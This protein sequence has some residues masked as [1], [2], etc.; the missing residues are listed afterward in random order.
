VE[1]RFSSGGVLGANYTW[2]KFLS[3]TDTLNG[4]ADP[5]GTN[6]PSGGSGSIQ[7]YNNPKAERSIISFDIPQRLVVDYVLNLPFGKGQKFGAKANGVVNAAISGW[8]VNG[9]TT[10]E[11]GTPAYMS[12][13]GGNSLTNLF[14]GGT[15]RPNYQAGCSTK[16]AGSRFERSLSG[17]TWF[18]TG[19]FTAPGDLAF[20]NAPRVN[21]SIRAQGVD[22]FDFTASK[23][24]TLHDQMNL[25][26]KAEFFNLFNHTQFAPP[27]WFV[28]RQF[29]QILMQLNQQRLIQ[30][31][32]RLNY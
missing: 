24:T 28:D 10:F 14:G 17:A 6:G 18:N 15:L 5:H 29:G 13:S 23:A 30:V 32:L 20:G 2:G 27:S 9:I 1:K 12:I 3:D 11:N 16:G 19:C 7:D 21:G 4:G 26:F 25:Q 22:N 31:S 8:S